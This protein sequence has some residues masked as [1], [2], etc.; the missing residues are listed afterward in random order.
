MGISLDKKP[1]ESVTVMDSK[2]VVISGFW[3]VKP[4]MDKKPVR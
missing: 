1:R 3:T 2:K 4:L